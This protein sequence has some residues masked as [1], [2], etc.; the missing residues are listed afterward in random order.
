[1]WKSPTISKYVVLVL[2]LDAGELYEYN[3]VVFHAKDDYQFA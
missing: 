1:M 2:K 3:F